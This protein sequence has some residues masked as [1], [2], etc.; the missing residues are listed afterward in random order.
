MIT[1]RQRLRIKREMAEEKPTLW[2][3]KN[4]IT[5]EVVREVANQLEKKQMVK[6]RVQKSAVK[7]D[8]EVDSMAEELAEKTDSTRIDVRGRNFIIYKIGKNT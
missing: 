2:I 3:G 5:D 1:Q 6:I 7:Q 8:D 4:G